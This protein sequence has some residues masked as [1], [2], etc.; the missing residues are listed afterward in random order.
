MAK[1]SFWKQSMRVP[2]RFT[3]NLQGWPDA[4]AV[5]VYLTGELTSTLEISE[6]PRYSILSKIKAFY[7]NVD[8]G[9]DYTSRVPDDPVVP[10]TRV[11]PSCNISQFIPWFSD[12]A[13]H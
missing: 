4:T 8:C 11:T 7:P 6:S 12:R 10:R 1:F 9:T 5:P 2:S 3:K 13:Q